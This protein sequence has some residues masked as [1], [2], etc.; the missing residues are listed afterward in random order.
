MKI[1]EFA[2]RVNLDEAAYNELPHLDSHCL[3]S[4]L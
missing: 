4:S 3:P 1:V 2:N